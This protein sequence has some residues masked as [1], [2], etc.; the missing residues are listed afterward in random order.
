MRARLLTILAVMLMTS[1]L[2]AASAR[3][4]FELLP[5]TEGFSVAPTNPDG[6]SDQLAG[7]H[8]YTLDFAINL[9]EPSEEIRDLHL[10]LPPGFLEDPQAV[11]TCSATD[12]STPRQSPFGFNVSGE[13][14]PDQSQVGVVT[15]RYVGG[16]ERTFGIFN[17]DPPPGS[18]GELGLSPYGEP[19][20]AAETITESDEGFGAVIDIDDLPKT[21]EIERF[22]F[23]LWGNPWLV[24]HDALRGNC[25]NT[26]NPYNPFPHP[27]G[28]DPE[29][30]KEARLEPE[31]QPNPSEPISFAPGTC[32]I[33]N[34]RQ[35]PPAA[36]LTLPTGCDKD[37][38]FGL[39]ATSRPSEAVVV[40]S[41]QVPLRGCQDLD[42]DPEPF[43]AP[44][45][46]RA[47][48]TSGYDLGFSLSQVNYTPA[49]RLIEGAT[50]PSPVRR[51]SIAFPD[52][53][54]INPAAGAGLG[55]CTEG[56]FQAESST[57]P[58]GEGCPED[59]RIGEFTVTAPIER[60]DVEDGA[61][62]LA[63][64]FENPSKSFLG[65]YFVGHST[66]R[67]L[68]AA[69][70]GELRS[71]PKTGNLTAVIDEFPRLPY[72][73]L[74]IHFPEGPHS[75]FATPDHCG[76]PATEFDLSPWSDPGQERQF[77]LPTAITP[78]PG[79]CPSGPLPFR[80]AVSGDSRD[81][82]AG[83]YSPFE[84]QLSR[85]DSEQKITS[86]SATLPPG[87]LGKL[88]DVPA[89]SD[90]GIAAAESRSGH[91][92]Q[93]FPSCPADS[94]I[95]HTIAT[96]GVGSVLAEAPG[97]LYLAGPYQG[98]Q[99]SIVA[100]TPAISG[101]FDLGVI[102][103][104]S[105]IRIDPAT[106]QASIGSPGSDPIPQ[107]VDGIPLD[108]REIRVSVDRPEFTLNPTSCESSKIASSLAGSALDAAGPAAD[109]LATTD[110]PYQAI[111]CD[112]L[113]LR[114]GLSLHLKRKSRHAGFPGLSIEVLPRPGDANL[115][116]AQLT[117]PPTLFVSLARIA[118]IC[119]QVQFAAEQ[120]PPASAIGN[121]EASTPLLAEPMTGTA[122]LR[123]SENLLPDLVFDLHGQGFRIEL[124][125]RIDS[126]PKGG[127]RATFTELPDAPVSRFLLTVPGGKRGILES[128]A[129][130][131]GSSMHRA[132]VR[133]L[134]QSNRSSVT[135]PELRAKCAA[136]H[137][138]RKAGR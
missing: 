16:G 112:S 29:S 13:N 87:L 65:V 2:T 3:A 103:V 110:A 136:H 124:A 98:S 102:A 88:A 59:S 115:R 76:A 60:G 71:D 122:Y 9:R 23:V 119:T 134:A 7:S 129:N 17:L 64:A 82:Q 86:Y 80:P 83:A 50:A 128:A 51:A 63:A 72:S 56:Q 5:G 81:A 79:G 12:F 53:V 47:S 15:F 95:G 14:C 135:N 28:E 20:T 1:L 85:S 120:C 55:V 113:S 61:I 106:A 130:L 101:A 62:Y 109:T 111:N 125:G 6:S 37:I 49:G 35:F 8:P 19:I 26:V 133:F 126:A 116:S 30:F 121:V 32:S 4:A 10:T 57:T 137:R 58:Q 127:L 66:D 90:A 74:Q 75:L 27:E 131:C 138:H 44:S 84:M 114:P 77:S 94:L 104:R 31:P 69:L 45:D 25:L 52:G 97:S 93:E 118:A 67:G 39:T 21:Y 70:S 107:V 92:E 11:S 105:A 68:I 132:H 46:P 24:Q 78:G 48:S 117:L 41:V 36:H 33:G 89:C 43:A 40:R 91:S 96:Y 123:S 73:A 100:I 34:P 108:L 99:V 42:F 38:S 54:T 18:D 22:D